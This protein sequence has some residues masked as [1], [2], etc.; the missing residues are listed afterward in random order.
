MNKELIELQR[1]CNATCVV[2]P[3]EKCR[4]LGQTLIMN[5]SIKN[6]FLFAAPSNNPIFRE[7]LDNLSQNGNLTYFVIRKIDELTEENQNRYISLVKDREFEGYNL[8]S[9]VIIVFTVE[10]RDGLKK[11]SSELY[12]FCVVAF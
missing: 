2:I 3:D 8:P 4:E 12:H 5:A 9:N 6:E 1:E 11:I 7:K 10:D